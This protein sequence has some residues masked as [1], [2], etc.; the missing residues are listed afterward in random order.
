MLKKSIKQAPSKIQTSPK[1]DSSKLQT[2]PKQANNKIEK[3]P[4]TKQDPGISQESKE[5]EVKHDK[6]QSN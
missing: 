4:K 2:N 3:E 6:H 1:Q 5:K